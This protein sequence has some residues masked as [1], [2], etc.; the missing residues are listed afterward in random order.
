MRSHLLV[1]ALF[2]MGLGTFAH[3]QDKSDL[4]AAEAEAKAAFKDLQ[5]IEDTLKG[6]IKAAADAPDD[7][8]LDAAL[9]EVKAEREVA[10]KRLI[11]ATDALQDAGGDATKY[12]EHLIARKVMRA[13]AAAALGLV[14]GVVTEMKVWIAEHWT[15]I[16]LHALGF[17]LI[18]LISRML[19]K[20]AAGIVRRAF[21][22]IKG[23]ASNQL[24]EM[25]VKVTRGVVRIVGLMIA[26]EW[27]GAPIGPLLGGLGVLGLVVAFALQG[28][29]S[30]F[31][32]GV[33]ILINRPYDTGDYVTAA[34]VSGT[35]KSMTLVSTQLLTPDNRIILCPNNSI[36]GSTITNHT[37]LATRRM[38]L[39]V[40]VG[41]GDDLNKTRK[42]LL[43]VANDHEMVLADPAPVVDVSNLGDSSVDFTVRVWVDTKNA[44][45]FPM[46]ITRTIKQRLD[47]EGIEIPF[48]QRD[49]HMHQEG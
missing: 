16:L 2:V 13:D 17:I 10:L 29:L 46:A 26:L 39:I 1:L 9:E 27:V 7:K 11:N 33:M 43:E 8:D 4:G 42:V 30:N 31:A 45:P 22:R 20:I 23:S 15:T 38:D 40:G 19:G 34:G 44:V 12:N 6:A 3:A 49:V 48:P 14:A 18:I 21:D 25:A 47:A 24:K 37:A 32:S 36:W 41:Y 28:T 5:A 35:V